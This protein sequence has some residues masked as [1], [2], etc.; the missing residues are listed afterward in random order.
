MGVLLLAHREESLLYIAE[1]INPQQATYLS[2]I[3]WGWMM[4]IW[5]LWML[6]MLFAWYRQYLAWSELLREISVSALLVTCM[7]VCS[8][9]VAFGLY[10]GLWHATKTIRTEIQMLDE[11][12]ETSFSVKDWI[13]QALPFSLL[14]FV[15]IFVL[16]AIWWFWGGNWHPVLLFFVAVSV[17]TLPHMLTLEHLYKF[18]K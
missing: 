16:G 1:V 14:S 7:I 18:F 4:T 12:S 6:G 10:F 5:S 8:L 15:G 11:S 17:L 13:Q 9:W 2:A 3:D